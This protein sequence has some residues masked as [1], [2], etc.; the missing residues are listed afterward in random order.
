MAEG[1][2]EEGYHAFIRETGKEVRELRER[3][4][5]EAYKPKNAQNYYFETARL[6]QLGDELENLGK[7]SLRQEMA[8]LEEA[9]KKE[10]GV[11]GKRPVQKL[12]EEQQELFYDLETLK[13]SL[14]ELTVEVRDA[15]LEFPVPKDFLDYVNKQFALYE[16]II[17]IYDTL[18]EPPNLE[19]MLRFLNWIGTAE[20]LVNPALKFDKTVRERAGR[21]ITRLQALQD[22]EVDVLGKR[23]G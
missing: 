19:A 21:L 23:G 13:L 11:S 22:R 20:I 6:C 3:M 18:N 16:R 9:M 8:A 7:G 17:K 10:F 5:K 15:V 2:T 1:S 4:K 14:E 12:P